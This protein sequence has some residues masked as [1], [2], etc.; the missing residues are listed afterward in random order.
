MVNNPPS[1][2]PT[3]FESS[4]Q[5]VESK[6]EIPQFLVSYRWW[7]YDANITLQAYDVKPILQGVRFGFF[8]DMESAK[9]ILES[10]PSTVLDSFLAAIPEPHEPPCLSEMS[11]SEKA[12]EILRR[13]MPA[14][15]RLIPWRWFPSASGYPSDTQ[16]IAQ[17]IEAESHFQF[18]QI[19]FEDIVRSALGYKAPS[20]EWFLQQHTAFGNRFLEHMRANPEQMNFYSAVEKASDRR[21]PGQ[22]TRIFSDHPANCYIQHLREQSSFAH[23]TLAKCLVVSQL[24]EEHNMPLPD[25]PGLSFVAGPIQQLF[26]ENQCSLVDMFEILSDLAVQFHQKYTCSSRMSWTIP[27]NVSLER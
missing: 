13:S 21:T 22:Y 6:M 19:A 27:F 7:E 2:A 5:V 16:G 10:R 20:V 14:P 24:D 3:L 1:Q 25:T 11:N 26:K 4:S 17:E 12:G 15:P 23:Q 8:P 9:R 18:G